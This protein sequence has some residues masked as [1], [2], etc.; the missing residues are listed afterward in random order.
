MLVEIGLIEGKLSLT[1]EQRNRVLETW[2]AVDKHDKQPQQF[3]QLYRTHWGNTLYCHTK[4]NDF[5]DAAVLQ[6]V[7]MAKRYAP[8]KKHI[9]AQ[10]ADVHAGEAAVVARTSRVSY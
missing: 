1:M 8:A 3:N 9:S 7:K 5:V 4:I 6:R 2:N 10:Q